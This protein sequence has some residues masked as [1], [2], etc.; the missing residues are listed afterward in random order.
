MLPSLALIGSGD[1]TT[2]NQTS[3]TIKIG[4]RY[5]QIMCVCFHTPYQGTK[6]IC[7][8]INKQTQGTKQQPYKTYIQ[9]NKEKSKKEKNC[10]N[11]HPTKIYE[12]S[13]K[14]SSKNGHKKASKHHCQD[15]SDLYAYLLINYR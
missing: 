5:N 2:Y 9:H 3:D 4:F 15:L 12:L 7:S 1:Q 8:I 13:G 10:K 11:I 6:Q 14:R